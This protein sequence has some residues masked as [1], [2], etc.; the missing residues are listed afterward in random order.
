MAAHR[1]FQP[2]DIYLAAR[3]K[4]LPIEKHGALLTAS[5]ERLRAAL[6]GTEPNPAKIGAAGD[7]KIGAVRISNFLNTIC[8][9]G[10]I[11]ISPRPLLEPAQ[12]TK[13]RLYGQRHCETKR[14]TKA[15]TAGL[16]T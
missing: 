12:S 15:V 14:R 9:D 2:A 11:E 1:E 3:K 8:S 4:Y 10:S 16:V 6:T 7:V 5:A 13:S